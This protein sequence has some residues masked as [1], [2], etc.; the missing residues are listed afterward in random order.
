MSGAWEGVG[1]WGRGSPGG[2]VCCGR[3][4][5]ELPGLSVAGLPGAGVTLGAELSAA[6]V[7][8]GW[9]GLS[10]ARVVGLARFVGGRFAEWGGC[11]GRG[12]PEARVDCVALSSQ[13]R[14]VELDG[15]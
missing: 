2:V 11:R 14:S 15:G 3:R 13:L 12:L 8:G 7:A 10:G 1:G 6:R 5:L 9:G 4:W